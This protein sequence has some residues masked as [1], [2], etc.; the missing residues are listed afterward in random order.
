[1]RVG[2]AEMIVMIEM[3]D[4]AITTKSL[5]GTIGTRTR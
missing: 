5:E 1:M 4:E 2:T 3:N